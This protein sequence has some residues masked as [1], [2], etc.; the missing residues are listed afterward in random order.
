MT[1]KEACREVGLNYQFIWLRIQRYGYTLQ[2][3]VSKPKRGSFDA[4]PLSSK[5]TN[6]ELYNMF[7]GSDAIGVARAA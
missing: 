5:F 2:E 7:A 4:Q 1:L 6:R 3:A